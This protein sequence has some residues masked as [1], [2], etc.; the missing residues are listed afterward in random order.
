MQNTAKKDW[1]NIYVSQ[2][3]L[4]K[5]T[6]KARRERAKRGIIIGNWD[7][8]I[9]SSQ[10]IVENFQ[11]PADQGIKSILVPENATEIHIEYE[12]R[13]IFRAIP[14]TEQVKAAKEQRIQEELRRKEDEFMG[15]HDDDN[16]DDDEWCFGYA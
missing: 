15:Y 1:V 6:K 13:K 9:V 10:G 14:V 4:F 11:R 3:P 5:P 12:P 7:I 2:K 8:S 16:N